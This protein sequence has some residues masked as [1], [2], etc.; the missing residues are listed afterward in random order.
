MLLLRGI[1]LRMC[2]IA[3]ELLLLLLLLLGLL[4]LVEVLGCRVE[5][6]VGLGLELASKALKTVFNEHEALVVLN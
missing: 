1:Q 6:G 3:L 4:R 2:S 5:L